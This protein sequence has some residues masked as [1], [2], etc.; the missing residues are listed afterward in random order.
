MYKRKRK[1]ALT[2]L[3]AALF[4]KNNKHKRKIALALLLVVLTIYAAC[5][6]P[7]TVSKDDV[8][9]RALAYRKAGLRLLND[10]VKQ[11]LSMKYGSPIN[12][13]PGVID[14]AILIPVTTRKI[15]TPSLQTLPLMTESIPTI[16]ATVESNFNYKV[17]VG[18]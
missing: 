3:L 2:C 13:K 8:H 7:A 10:G 18:F 17:Y 1:I 15:K 12:R 4:N 5:L 14:V 9:L 6:K 11:T 16:I